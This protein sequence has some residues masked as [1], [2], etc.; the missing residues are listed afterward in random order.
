MNLRR[1]RRGCAPR[2]M[3]AEPT[4]QRAGI[5]WNR[6][7]QLPPQGPSLGAHVTDP[8]VCV[9][10]GEARKEA[11][12]KSWKGYRERQQRPRAQCE[13]PGRRRGRHRCG[14]RAEPENGD[15]A[16]PPARSDA[17][18]RP[19]TSCQRQ[20]PR[21]HGDETV[22]DGVLAQDDNACGNLDLVSPPK[23][24]SQL[25]AR[26]VLEQRVHDEAPALPADCPARRE[27]LT[28]AAREGEMGAQTL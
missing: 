16:G 5:T 8:L 27:G 10:F 24:D 17:A 12:T 26:A 25:T 6:R 13:H 20:S 23:Q 18:D 9:A 11:T 2:L 22:A 3:D 7:A 1:G 21:E 14:L 28:H 19:T 4:W 15:V